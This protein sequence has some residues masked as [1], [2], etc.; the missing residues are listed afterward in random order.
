MMGDSIILPVYRLMYM[1]I[2][3]HDMSDAELEQVL[4]EARDFNKAEN[5]GGML[6]YSERRFVQYLEGDDFAVESL[7]RRIE[8][9]PRHHDVTRLFSGF[10]PRRIFGCWYMGFQHLEGGENRRVQ[11]AIDLC[12]T[13]VRDAIPPDAPE[14]IIVFMQNFYLNSG[15]LLDH[16]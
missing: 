13:A 7:Y 14:E 12:T 5:I 1:S 3:G 15:S 10:Y 11:G 8:K 6:L 4:V 9:D 16:G 2:A